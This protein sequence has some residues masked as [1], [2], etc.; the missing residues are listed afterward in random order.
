MTVAAENQLPYLPI[1]IIDVSPYRSSIRRSPGR[2]PAQARGTRRRIGAAIAALLLLAGVA[3]ANVG[4]APVR[5]DA[6]HEFRLGPGNAL[7][8]G[9]MSPGRGRSTPGFLL[10]PGHA[11]PPSLAR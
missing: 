7:P 8:A 10:G 6:S 2:S 11:T 5:V 1:K 3:A 4:A 9:L